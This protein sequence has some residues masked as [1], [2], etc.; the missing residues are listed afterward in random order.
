MKIILTTDRTLM[1][2]YRNIPLG[3]FL[4]CVPA[5]IVPKPIFD[6]LAPPEPPLDKRGE[7]RVAPYGLRKIE[8]A[9]LRNNYTRKD[10][11]VVHPDYIHNFIKEDTRIIGVYTMDPFGLGPVSMMFTLGKRYTSYDEI[12]FR[13]LITKLNTIRQRVGLKFKI[14]VGG[15][16]TWQL[17]YKFYDSKRLGI[18][19]IVIGEADHVVHEIFDHIMRNDAPEIINITTWPS[20]DQIPTI[21]R[22]SLQGIVEVMRGCGRGCAF[23]LPNM[24]IARYIPLEKI[25]EETKVNI[26]YGETTIWLHSEDIFLY[27]LEDRKSFTPN[28]EALLKL[29]RSI[30]SIRG[31]KH[32]HPTHSSIAPV[33]ADPEMVTQISKILR[34]GPDNW[35]GIQPG[36]ETGSRKLIKK[37]MPNKPKPFSSDEWQD[38]A[39]EATVIF[40]MNYWFPAYTLIVGLPGETD[41]DS[42]DTVRMLDRLEKEVPKRV[43]KE[44]THFITAPLSF[45]PLSAL[46][47]EKMFDAYLEMNHARFCVI[48]RAWRI[49]VKEIYRSL[50]WLVDQPLPIKL[51]IDLISMLGGKLIL[52]RLEKYGRKRGYNINKCFLCN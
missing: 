25:L 51:M 16:G 2:K 8:A 30:M 42:W 46:H 43:G 32:C 41:E 48:Y 3:N 36:L 47:K 10:V 34:A 21:T 24:R 11:V 26:A 19:H 50:H 17:A 7:A 1:S 38:L 18:D 40:N 9:L 15:P 52:R 49:I 44:K 39:V 4:G 33:V 35:I 27:E 6:F 12:E 28:R 13:K 22:A 14:V 23:C 29:F 45:V 37:H 31:V 5:D 20:V